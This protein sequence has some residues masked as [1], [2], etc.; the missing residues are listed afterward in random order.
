MIML[1]VIVMVLIKIKHNYN[2]REHLRAH[3]ADSFLYFIDVINEFKKQIISFCIKR[4]C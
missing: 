2:R 1:K 3:K 4:S